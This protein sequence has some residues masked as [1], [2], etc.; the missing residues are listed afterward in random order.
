MFLP[1]P[2]PPKGDF[3]F[4]EHFFCVTEM[5]KNPLKVIVFLFK[6]KNAEHSL[7]ILFLRVLLKAISAWGK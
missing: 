5:Y 3:F 4:T 6:K 7:A 1:T 2:L